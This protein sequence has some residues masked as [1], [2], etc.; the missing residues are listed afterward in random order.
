MDGERVAREAVAYLA[1]HDLVFDWRFFEDDP[2]TEEI[3][4]LV[5]P[6]VVGMAKEYAEV[7]SRYIMW[8]LMQ[9]W[10]FG[11]GRPPEISGADEEGG[12]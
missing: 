8:S 9:D 12:K 4:R 3:Q 7:A 1:T 5:T 2:P 10:V 6:Y 11:T